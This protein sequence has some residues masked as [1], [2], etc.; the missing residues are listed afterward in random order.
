MGGH[1]IP[2]RNRYKLETELNGSKSEV[3][4]WEVESTTKPILGMDSF[5][6]LGL[7]LIQRSIKNDMG[8][9]QRVDSEN[10]DSASE[11]KVTKKK[12]EFKKFKKEF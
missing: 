1:P 7:N 4:W 6:K 12:S 2:I 3:I 10:N 5:D 8:T 11:S 9:V